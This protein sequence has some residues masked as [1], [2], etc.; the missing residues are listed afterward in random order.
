MECF[1]LNVVL[2]QGMLCPVHDINKD[3][4]TENIRVLLWFVN[5]Y[6]I[7]VACV[8]VTWFASDSSTWH[9]FVTQN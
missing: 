3:I 1:I 6:V 2:F 9:M 5:A 4:K 8:K 7:A